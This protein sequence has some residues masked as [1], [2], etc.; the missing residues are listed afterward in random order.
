MDWQLSFLHAL[1][2]IR[3][4]VLDVFF[5]I[6][7]YLGSE[8]GLIVVALVCFWC[9]DKKNA[10]YLFSVGLL[11]TVFNQFLKITCRIP[12]PWVLDPTL[13]PVPSAVP[14]ATGYSFPSGHTQSSVGLFGAMLR[15]WKKTWVRI[16]CLL[17]VLLVPFSRMYL[18]VHTP[19]DVLV[20]FIIAAALVLGFYPILER[21][22]GNHR[23]MA[24]LL[25]SLVA[26]AALYLVY[27]L[28]APFPADVDAAH[29]ASALK[30][31]YT[32][33][34]TLLGLCLVYFL[35]ERYIHSKTEAP[36]PAQIIK[37]VGGGAL[38]FA[39]KAGLKSPLTALLG[40][41]VEG[42]PRYFLLVVFAGAVWPLIFPY[43]SRL[44]EKK[45]AN[46]AEN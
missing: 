16:L 29:L 8:T 15:M 44:F 24:I 37:L 36:L 23:R 43:L 35:D 22:W 32:L 34:G 9:L 7:T 45:S 13:S 21:A 2:S 26:A 46:T 33:L 3:N 25:S 5:G 6:I 27:V 18:G 20:S 40:A 30:N 11:G 14:E 10:Y 38:A 41:G 1:E 19:M 42:L 4:P 28:V 17:P 31:G 12:R 39:L